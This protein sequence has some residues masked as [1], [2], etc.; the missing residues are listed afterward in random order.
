LNL[1]ESFPIVNNDKSNKIVVLNH[2][3]KP[4]VYKSWKLCL[5]GNLKYLKI[6]SLIK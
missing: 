3:M 2:M 6:E 4:I 1:I 5:Y